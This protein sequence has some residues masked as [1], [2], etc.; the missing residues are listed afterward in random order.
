MSATD[1]AQATLI[2]FA[3]AAV[4]VVTVTVGGVA[5]A[6]DALADAERAPARTHAAE[7]LAAHLVAVDGAHA[8]EPNVLREAALAN[9]TL[10]DVDAAVPPV[11]DRAVRVSVGDRVLLARGG[12][13]D[14][15]GVGDDAPSSRVVRRVR[16]EREKPRTE[17]VDLED[18]R[19]ITLDAHAGD[20]ALRIDPAPGQSV[21]TVRADGRVLLHDPD[22]LDGRYAVS[23]PSVHPLEVAFAV[24]GTPALGRS[25]T[26]TV[27]WAAASGRTEPLEVIVGA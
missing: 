12:L 26:V 8:R 21:T 4:V 17:R 6:D 11:R 18:R 23:L 3:V 27:R 25:G 24:R 14:S 20:A 19:S 5:I 22:G 10:A 2:G 15:A 13:A 9:L 16:I 1:R 7:R